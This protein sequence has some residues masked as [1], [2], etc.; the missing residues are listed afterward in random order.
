M[1]IIHLMIYFNFFIYTLTELLKKYWK[2]LKN[3]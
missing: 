1:S 3:E 2:K